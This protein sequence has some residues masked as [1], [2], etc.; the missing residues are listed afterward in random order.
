MTIIAVGL[1]AALVVVLQQPNVSTFEIDQN[2]AALKTEIRATEIESEQYAGGVIKVLLDLRMSI[3]RNTLAMLD[4]KRAS[5]IRRI[6]LNYT[7][8]GRQ[9]SQA[10]D[11]DLKDILEELSQA[12]RKV[13]ASRQEAAQYSGGLLQSMALLKAG[14]EELNVSQLRLKFYS[15]KYGIPMPVPSSDTKPPEPKPPGRVVK[16]RDAL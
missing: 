5:F 8:E 6:A 13:A 3:L 11:N 7:I 15:A 9:I 12:E 1:A 14:T 4:Q 2:R 16:D 10:S